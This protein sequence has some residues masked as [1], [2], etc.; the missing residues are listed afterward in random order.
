MT[1]VF[2]TIPCFLNTSNQTFQLNLYFK[3]NELNNQ[4]YFIFLPIELILLLLLTMVLVFGKINGDFKFFIIHWAMFSVILGIYMGI[5][6]YTTPNFNLNLGGSSLVMDTI[7]KTLPR[8]LNACS[9]IL[10]AFNRFVILYNRQYYKTLFSKYRLF[11]SI[12]FYDLL[13]CGVGVANKIFNLNQT[14]QALV[15][16]IYF[17]FTL[18]IIVKFYKMSKLASVDSTIQDSRR[19][20]YV[21]A[22]M[23]I[24]YFVYFSIIMFTTVFSQILA[25]TEYCDTFFTTYA[26]ILPM[27]E[28]LNILVVICDSIYTLFI[29]KTYRHAVLNFMRYLAK[30]LFKKCIFSTDSVEI[31]PTPVTR[32][33][34]TNHTWAT[35]R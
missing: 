34:D 31:I 30:I 35:P 10:L 25:Y 22:A 23:A 32:F 3:L 4:L 26:A 21:C 17:I 13:M 15:Y 6:K 14:T 1:M 16:I 12:F 9:L 18:L 27:Q 11:I 24:T 5:R 20:I 19:A 33:V 7:F 28:S 8:F 29:L 2:S